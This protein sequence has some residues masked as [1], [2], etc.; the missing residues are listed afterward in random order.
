M[1]RV[2]LL[3][4]SVY[5]IA[6]G[7]GQ[8]PEDPI[9]R[10]YLAPSLTPGCGR[11]VFAG[12]DIY[13]GETMDN[14]VTLAL[15]HGSITPWQLNNYVWATDEDDI[16]MAEFGAGMLFNHRPQGLFQHKWPAHMT[17]STDQKLAHTTFSSV[18][19][20]AERDISAGEEIFVS[21]SSGNEWLEQRG[22]YVSETPF[23]SDPPPVRSVS[24]LKEIGHCI[25]HVKVQ[26]SVHD[27]RISR[28]L[29]T[30]PNCIR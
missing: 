5:Q 7:D 1:K 29:I 10:M 28:L 6:A 24:E 19:N 18:L 4:F 13:S 25:T 26:R 30:I 14:S 20:V 15:H 22:I 21:Y 9:C 8:V 17:K 3:G 2:C 27:R 11:G 12:S 23:T 16:S